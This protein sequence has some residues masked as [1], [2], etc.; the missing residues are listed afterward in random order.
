MKIFASALVA[1]LLVVGVQPSPVID[2]GSVLSG[3]ADA[4]LTPIV[5]AQAYRP[6]GCCNDDFRQ[7]MPRW[8]NP[9]DP[10]IAKP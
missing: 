8:E 4:T 10:I 1:S 7:P 3:S 6:G 9:L 2:A 5:A